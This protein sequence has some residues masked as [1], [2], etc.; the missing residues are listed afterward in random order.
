MAGLAGGVCALANCGA[1][2]TCL[3]HVWWGA[4]GR[5]KGVIGH[6]LG[7]AGAI[8]A[9]CTVLAFR[10]RTVPAVVDFQAQEAVT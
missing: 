1:V 7:A 4:V 2:G 3:L 5:W 10:H 6:S 9:A 8:D